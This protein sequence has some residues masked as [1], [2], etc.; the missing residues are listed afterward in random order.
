LL[1][2]IARQK[3]STPL[4]LIKANA[5]PRLPPDRYSLTACN[6]RFKSAKK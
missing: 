1:M 4:P 2:E 5:G 6:Y 3:N